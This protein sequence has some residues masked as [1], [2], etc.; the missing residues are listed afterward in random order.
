MKRRL[1]NKNNLQKIKDIL[2]EKACIIAYDKAKKSETEFIP[3]EIAFSDIERRRN[4][5]K[6]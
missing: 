6:C 4:K 3:V 2:E 1:I 5:F